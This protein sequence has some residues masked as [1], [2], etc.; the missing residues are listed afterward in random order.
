MYGDGEG[1]YLRVG[2]TGG[3]SWILRTTV[4]G[5]RRSLGLGSASLVSLAE[6]R[7]KGRS[8]RKVARDGGDPFQKRNQETLT[9]AAA[10]ERVHAEYTPT[11]RNAKHAQTWLASIERYANPVI[12]DRPMTNIVTA[13]LLM[14]LSP[15]WTTKHETAK[16]LKQRLSTI[17][18]WAKGNGFYPNENPLNGVTKSL[19]RVSVNPEHMAAMH[20][21]TLPTFMEDLEDREGVSARTLEFIILTASRSNEARGA[22]WRE[23]DLDNQIW[24]VPGDRMKRGKPHRVPLSPEAIAILD[25]QYG[26]DPDYVFPSA[27]RGK[28]GKSRPQSVM[29]FKALFKRM[30]RDGFTTHGFRSTYR[31]W[32]GEQAMVQRE[33]AEMAL[34]HAIGNQTERAYARSDLFDRRRNLMN[35]WAAFATGKTGRVTQLVRA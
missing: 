6:A 4:F 35:A 21:Q 7:E 19:P 8:L 11:W 32:C 1:L 33:L 23:V 26:L 27:T 34:A 2:P 16:R 15:I 29:V 3:K 20:W 12:G 28:D 18:D 13:D 17:F 25:R 30:E 14:V 24:T 22:R 5:K 9:F 10:A 31:D